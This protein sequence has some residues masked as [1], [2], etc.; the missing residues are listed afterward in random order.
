MP[1][2]RQPGGVG[3]DEGWRER[4]VLAL[5]KRAQVRM[6]AVCERSPPSI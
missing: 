4:P 2:V 3:G 6:V 1:A 5:A